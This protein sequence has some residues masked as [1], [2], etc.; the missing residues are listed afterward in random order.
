VRDWPAEVLIL[1]KFFDVFTNPNAETVLKALAPD[2]V[3]VY[4]VALDVCVRQA[5]EGIAAR[6]RAEL[7][8]VNDATCGL[9]PEEQETLLRRLEVQGVSL[10]STDAI[11]DRHPDGPVG[12]P[13]A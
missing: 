1:K 8:L 12:L 4:G 3:V 13:A 5:V 7:W 10:V 11:I 6:S 2:A 9:H